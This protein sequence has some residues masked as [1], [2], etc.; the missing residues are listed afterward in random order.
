M[1]AYRL[2]VTIR[3]IECAACAAVFTVLLP[4]CG[5]RS[6]LFV[7]AASTSADVA[8]CPPT[9]PTCVA[10]GDDACG[11][12]RI[13]T[14]VCDSATR[15][16][17]CPD[18]SIPYVRAAVETM[19]CRPFYEPGGPI[20]SLGGSLVRVPTDDG[21]CLWIAED[22]TFGTGGTICNVAFETD[23]AAPFGTCP[24][25]ATFVG[26][27]ARTIVAVDSGDEPT[28]LVSITGAYRLAGATRVTYRLFR[29]DGGPAFGLTEL[30]T[31]LG[32]WDAATQRIVVP[33]P[34]SL[35]FG[36]DLD[37]GDA[38]WASTD[39]AYV[40]GCPGP[41]DFLT[42]R[43][44]VG[45]IDAA[46]AMELFAGAGR[47]I[48]SRRGRDA[49]TVFDAG[50]WVSSVVPNGAAGRLLH[51]FAV[52]FGTDLQIHT[53]S[54]PEGPWSPASRLA[55]CDVPRDD[56][57]AYCAGPVVHRE[58]TDPTRAGD[59]PV[60]YGVGSTAPDIAARAAANPGAYWPRLQWLTA[61]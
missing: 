53:A 24:T 10:R 29:A 39:R 30:G 58:L 9:S 23:L 31:G 54:A 45:R 25:R 8:S 48:A 33:G 1:V 15:A 7:V 52:G 41:P 44:V 14:A 40:W 32:R 6:D 47:W 56:S 50:P 46:G 59:L 21:R 22:V 57:H 51:L 60:T 12:P 5:A 34:R 37:L 20:R 28:L 4:S 16:W 18:G 43:C 26:G 36:P 42:E 3:G 17:R 27:S 2:A 61:P 35:A 55:A 19:T 13:V 11:P 49:A 38:S